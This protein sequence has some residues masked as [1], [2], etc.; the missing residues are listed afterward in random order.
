MNP[1]LFHPDR[2]IIFTHE[3]FPKKGGISIFI[4]EVASSLHEMGRHVTIFAP[5]H[6]KMD[7]EKF[8]YDLRP[9]EYKGTQ[10][11]ASRIKCGYHLIKNRNLI[12]NSILYLPEPGPIRTLMVLQLLPLLTPKKLIMT[13]HGSEINQLKATSYRRYL[14]TKLANNCE[15]ISVLSRYTQQLL[16]K[17]FP[18]TQSKSI[19]S[20]GAVRRTLKTIKPDQDKSSSNFTI[21]TV[22][23]IHPRKGQDRML[24]AINQLEPSFKNKIMYYIVGPVVDHSYYKQ[25][26][27]YAESNNIN[28]KFSGEVDEDRLSG[29]Y[30]QADLFAMTSRPYKKSIEGFGLSYLEASANGIPIIAHKTGGVE[31]VVKNGV[32][33]L[34]V[35]PDDIQS[36]AIGLDRL[37]T[38]SKYRMAMSKPAR[39][40]ARNFSWTESTRRIFGITDSK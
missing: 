26:L 7:Q 18:N 16:H 25:L 32:N 33:G 27:E 1:D 6:E 10:G 38:N 14:F 2:I 30:R 37:I 24:K 31:D 3:F 19:I 23:R 4:Q 20:P 28:A 5:Y 13:L 11:W 15:C 40:W 9:M 34:L 8:S 39:E 21:I 22:A 12:K 35:D 36:L 17:N 29:L